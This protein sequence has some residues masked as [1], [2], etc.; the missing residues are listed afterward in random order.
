M[1]VSSLSSHFSLE[2]YGSE[3]HQNMIKHGWKLEKFLLTPYMKKAFDP[4]Y[5]VFNQHS[6]FQ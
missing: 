5:I 4:Y 6:L 1:M 3:N 2:D